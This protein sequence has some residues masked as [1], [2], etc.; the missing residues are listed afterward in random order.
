[1]GKGNCA[2]AVGI[3]GHTN[4][5]SPTFLHEH[6]KLLCSRGIGCDMLQ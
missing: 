5:N 4:G 2:G 3:Y 6:K 1:M